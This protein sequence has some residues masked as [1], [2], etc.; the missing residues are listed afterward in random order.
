MY[1]DSII[2]WAVV[3][4]FLLLHLIAPPFTINTYQDWD[5]ESSGSE[6]KLAS[7]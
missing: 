2:D 7:V 4:C 3:A 1:S 6:S 5:F